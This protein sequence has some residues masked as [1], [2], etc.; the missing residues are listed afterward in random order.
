[1]GFAKQSG[2]P[3][4]KSGKIG[5]GGIIS[6]SPVLSKQVTNGIVEISKRLG[7]DCD[8]EVC[9]GGTGT[10]ADKIAS[11]GCGVKTGVISVPS[12]NMHTQTEIVSLD[13]MEKISELLSIYVKEGGAANA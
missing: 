11:S 3:D 13:D 1:M 4:E 5:C 7:M 6:I 10:N 12:K 8:Y 2:V 9:G